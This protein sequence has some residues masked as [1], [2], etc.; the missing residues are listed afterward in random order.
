MRIEHDLLGELAVPKDAYYGIHTFRAAENFS[1][2]GI[3]VHRELI[4]AFALIKLA[5]ASANRDTGSL[6]PNLAEAII[7]ACEEILRGKFSEDFILDALQGG[8]GTSTNMNINEVIANRASELLGGVRGSYSPVHP[9]EHVNLS[10]STNDVYP[11]AIRIAAISLL[12][13]LTKAFALLQ[14]AFQAKEQEFA[15]IAKLG[16]TQLQDA[17]PITLG[18]EFGAF[19]QAFARDRWRLYKVEERLRVIPLGGTAIGTGLNANRQYI[20]K[21]TDYIQDLTGLGLA[22]AEN[23]VELNQN[24]DVF[25][26]VSGLLK[27]S[28]VNLA[29][30]AGD[31]RLLASGPRGGLGEISLPP[32]QAGSSIMPGKVNPV[33]TEAVTQVAYQVIANDTAITLAAQAGQLELNAFGPLISHNLLQSLE[34]LE[35]AVTNLREK[36]VVGI[37]ANKK[38]CLELLESSFALLTALCPVIGYDRAGELSR[39]AL[40]MNLSIPQVLQKNGLLQDPEVTRFLASQNLIFPIEI[41]D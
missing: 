24:C 41:N 31:L 17:V 26:E 19:A 12:K 18:Q 2:S 1:L 15:A 38:R 22:R 7:T 27:A 11:T 36:C 14:E 28:A 6:Q 23:T 40:E 37:E 34:L 3:L 25:V 8:A 33:I 35:R 10:Q 21:V 5:A 20:Y 30:V 39:Q 4:R 32:V 29:K 9:I 16:R 13:R